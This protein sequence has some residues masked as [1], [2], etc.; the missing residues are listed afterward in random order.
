MGRIT[1]TAWLLLHVFVG[2]VNATLIS[3]NGV[4]KNDI[5]NRY[6]LQDIDK[7]SGLSYVEQLEAIEQLNNSIAWGDY[8]IS[9]WRMATASDFSILVENCKLEEIGEI[10]VDNG[11][12]SGLYGRLNEDE[13]SNS[14]ADLAII[15]GSDYNQDGRPDDYYTESGCVLDGYLDVGAWVVAEPVPE[16]TS[17]L[18]FSMGLILCIMRFQKKSFRNRQ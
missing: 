3:N 18:M 6:W 10:F 15:F 11:L 9:G 16:P 12:H 5:T 13:G 14:H 17:V 7:F 4:L 8:F 2:G 1:L